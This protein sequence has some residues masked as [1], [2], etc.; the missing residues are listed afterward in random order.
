MEQTATGLVL[1]RRSLLRA[2]GGVVAATATATARPVSAAAASEASGVV[3][4]LSAHMA[5]AATRSLPADALE[6][7]K[8][9]L[10]DTLAAMISGSN[11]APGRVGMAFARANAGATTATVVGTNFTCGALE[12]AMA[13]GMLAHSDETDDSHAASHS[14]PGCSVVPAALAVGEQ[15]GIDGARLLRAVDARVRRRAPRDV[16]ARRLAISDRDAPQH[17]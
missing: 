5:S 16:H 13:N 11:L 7:T 9:H 14:H 2:A 6:K 8:H 3:D 1:T 12:A 10:L 15:F 4:T 17:A